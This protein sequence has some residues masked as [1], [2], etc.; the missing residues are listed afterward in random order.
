VYE[1]KNWKMAVN[2]IR[3]ES[4]GAEWLRERAPV[5]LNKLLAGKIRRETNTENC[6]CKLCHQR[7]LFFA[8]GRLPEQQQWCVEQPGQ[9]RLLL[10]QYC[11]EQQ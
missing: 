7:L 5:K 1:K 9:Q 6:V 3:R 10:E 11:G 4:C 2:D 8:S